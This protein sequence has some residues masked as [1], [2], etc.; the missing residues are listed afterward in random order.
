MFKEISLASIIIIMALLLSCATRYVSEIRK[1]PEAIIKE[2]DPFIKVNG[3]TSSIEDCRNNTYFLKSYI[4]KKYKTVVH[5]IYVSYSYG[6]GW[7]FYD[8]ATLPDAELKVTK[9][10]NMAHCDFGKFTIR[11]EF[12]ITLPDGYIESHSGGF[13]VTV[14]SK[15]GHSMFINISQHQIKEQLEEVRSLR[16]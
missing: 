13:S 3:I 14:F 1:N 12:I 15:S 4:D 5:Q 10:G 9:V 16:I 6:S 2:Y 11:E 7:R 8:E